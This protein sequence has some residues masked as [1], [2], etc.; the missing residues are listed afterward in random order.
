M[1]NGALIAR[2]Y[3]QQFNRSI[4]PTRAGKSPA[5]AAWGIYRDALISDE[6][7]D[8]LFS[9]PDVYGLAVITGQHLAVIDFDNLNQAKA[10]QAH[11]PTL[12]D[13]LR[14]QTPRGLHLFFT[15]TP[16]T[17]AARKFPGPGVDFIYGGYTILPPTP[18]YSVE[19]ESVPLYLSADEYAEICAFFGGDPLPTKGQELIE[20]T[21]RP[22]LLSPV[23]PEHLR[24]IYH[25]HQ[26]AGR[27]NA[28]FKAC[29]YAYAMGVSEEMAKTALAE[30]YVYSPA[31]P[32]HKR[33]GRQARYQEAVK[34]IHSAYSR[35][36]M[37]IRDT[38]PRTLPAAAHQV[39]SQRRETA[40]GRAL[41]KLY[42]S[43]RR[44][45]D[46][47]TQGEIRES[48]TDWASRRVPDFLAES[49][50]SKLRKIPPNPP[51]KTANADLPT[52]HP[53]EKQCYCSDAKPT[54]TYKDVGGRPQIGYM[55]PSPK[56]ICNYLGVGI[57]LVDPSQLAEL[58]AKTPYRLV[59]LRGLLRRVEGKPGCN[60][61][62]QA[63]IFGVHPSTIRRWHDR[64][65]V[66]TYNPGRTLSGDN[67]KMLL[68]EDKDDQWIEDSTGKRYPAK[69]IIAFKLWGRGIRGLTLHSLYN[70]TYF[71]SEAALEAHHKP[72]ITQLPLKM[73]GEQPK[74]IEP[75]SRIPPAPMPAASAPAIDETPESPAPVTVPVNSSFPLLH[76]QYNDLLKWYRSEFDANN[77][78][79]WQKA[80][81]L[82]DMHLALCDNSPAPMPKRP[83]QKAGQP[84]SDP[85][86][87]GLAKHL[88]EKLNR[89]A[90]S[91]KRISLQTMR[92]LLT[93]YGEERVKRAIEIASSHYRN[94]H[95]P[96]GYF[97]VAVKGDD[98][99]RDKETL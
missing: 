83:R 56:E 93:A 43:G 28:L 85:N 24:G 67:I 1:R 5:T 69:Q 47:I 11:F 19:R 95:N 99:L 78:A 42:K 15:V 41:D 77:L 32:G 97:I 38:N 35:Q 6:A 82:V 34:T 20:R 39:L 64:L 18:G 71:T 91:G 29:C 55:L 31:P 52:K 75:P 45:G 9:L 68:P 53:T 21:F 51:K 2:G 57:F 27:N 48:N 46:I 58:D 7:L 89:F 80:F 44:A 12:W 22:N 76:R 79:H 62:W 96:V 33:Q 70:W 25:A 10:F 88:Q 74:T 90:A 30:E 8:L 49:G 37:V 4:I 94:I 36:P 73:R 23:T 54:K 50:L 60:Q 66:I 84:L 86:A 65:G 3:K 17:V 92:E 59:C 87:E 98:L 61:V 14:H 26:D 13:T 72:H 16:G 40:V 81:E 63:R